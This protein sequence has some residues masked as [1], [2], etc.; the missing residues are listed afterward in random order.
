MSNLKPKSF[1]KR[2]EGKLGA[3]VIL[4]GIASLAIFHNPIIE[5]ILSMF[6]S[7]L[8]TMG[9]FAIVGALVMLI[10][11]KRTRNLI[12]FA[13]QGI[14]RKITGI[15]VQLDPIKILES[16]VEYLKKNR[17]D[18]NTNILKLR[19]QL[20]Q[21]NAT[22][23]QNKNEMDQKIRI[24][25]QAKLQNRTELVAINTRQYGR[26]SE[27]NNKYEKMIGKMN[28]LYNVL[29]KIHTSTA[30]L[31]QDT[32]NEVRMRKQEA[33]AVMSGYSAMQHAMNIINGD[34]DRKMMFDMANQALADDIHYKIGEMD[35]F[36]EMSGS[37]I[38][39]VNI[40]NAA[41]EMKGLELIEKMEKMEKE[42]LSFLEM[43]NQL[44]QGINMT[45]AEIDAA[46]QGLDKKT[47]DVRDF[48]NLY[49]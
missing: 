3:G 22:V 37:F 43:S 9:L 2:P 16:Y 48:T 12:K 7:P 5:S 42:G 33:A 8:S 46:I 19:N 26:L 11:D 21:L 39:N 47:G 38:D 41:Y 30:Y 49:Q 15:F 31:I 28:T 14:M 27:L 29:S 36:I 17:E 4:G 1:W 20:T 44:N 35:R 40:D 10:T 34:P 6:T 25:R 13:F 32:E 23:N 45:D 18:M 24:A